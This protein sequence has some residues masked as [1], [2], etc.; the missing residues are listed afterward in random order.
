MAR[1]QSIAAA[2]EAILGLL[3]DSRPRPEYESAR[4]D[5]FQLKDFQ[6][7]MD[8]GLSLYLYRIGVNG[9]RRN[10][11]P[12]LGLDGKR[13]RPALPLDLHFLLTA[14]AK[15]AAVQQRL[16][17]WAVRAL[18][19]VPVLPASFLNNYAPEPE[20]FRPNEAVELIFDPLSLADMNNLWGAAKTTPPLSVTYVLR[21]L[22]IESEV[23]IAE[24]G[25]LVQ[26]RGFDFG[27]LQTK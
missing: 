13:Y 2:G 8:E 24:G 6:A 23:E 15:T 11:P 22:A 20:V 7:G 27:G 25:D 19:D 26:A 4:F 9:S 12:T 17:G 5:L 21:M 14:W 1:Y 3:R 10:L 16:L 18:Q